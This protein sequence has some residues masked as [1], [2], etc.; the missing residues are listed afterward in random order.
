VI[1]PHGARL[2]AEPGDRQHGDLDADQLC[3]TVLPDIGRDNKL[4]NGKDSA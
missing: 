1:A 4:T 2:G 3:D